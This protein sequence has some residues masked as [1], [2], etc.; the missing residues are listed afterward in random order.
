MTGAYEKIAEEMQNIEK[1]VQ[2][3]QQSKTPMST[4]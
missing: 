3:Q 4:Q 2:M 1:T